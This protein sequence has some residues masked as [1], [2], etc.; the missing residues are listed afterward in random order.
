MRRARGFTL[1]EV[2]VAFVLLSLVLATSYEIF[3][4]GFARVADLE[5]YSRATV[6]AVDGM[7][8]WRSYWGL[9]RR[10]HQLD[11]D[12]AEE[13]TVQYRLSVGEK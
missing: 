4:S 1:I 9:L 6:V 5:D 12:P 10:A 8:A 2:V 7:P 3:S 13:V 11:I